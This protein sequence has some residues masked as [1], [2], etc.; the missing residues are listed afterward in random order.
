MKSFIGGIHPRYDKITRK[1]SVKV[2]QLPKRVILP[3][4]QHTGAIC[5]AI[6]NAG[7][8][9]KV[10]QKIAE[11]K[12]FVSAC[13]H[14][15]ISGKVLGIAKAKHPVLGECKAVVIESDGKIEWDESVKKRENVDKLTKDE[16]KVIIKEAGIVGVGGAAFPTH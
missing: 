16:L 9:V 7:D 5:E 12:E 2:A 4:Q 10:G 1:D 11:S 3:L 13:I 6:V 15:S 14:A 8:E